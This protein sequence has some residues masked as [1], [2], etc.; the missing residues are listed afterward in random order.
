MNIKK[1]ARKLSVR[2]KKPWRKE[3]RH[4]R[5]RRKLL[6]I[7]I[8]SGSRDKS[9]IGVAEE[10][11]S[12]ESAGN[13]V[14]DRKLCRRVLMK[15]ERDRAERKPSA[16]LAAVRIGKTDFYQHRNTKK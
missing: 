7:L 6:A 12:P 5:R 8:G 14:S 10:V 11:I 1:L 16:L 9:A 3:L 15:I 13:S 4:C 2:S